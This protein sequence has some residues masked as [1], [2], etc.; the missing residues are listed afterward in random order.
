[1]IVSL[2]A[3][4]NLSGVAT[5]YYRIG[6]SGSFSVYDATQPP[7]ISAD[8]T[9]PV[10]FYSVDVAGN[11][12]TVHSVTVNLDRLCTFLALCIFMQGIAQE[13]LLAVLCGH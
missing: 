8:G 11:S 5:T 12:E 6:S 1:M 3:T 10:Y 4:D 7:V 13:L 9:T 2:S